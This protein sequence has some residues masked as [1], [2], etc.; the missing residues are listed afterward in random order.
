MGCLN[1]TAADQTPK[2]GIPYVPPGPTTQS[3]QPPVQRISMIDGPHNGLGYNQNPPLLPPS[4]TPE[5]DG[6]IFVARY[7]YQA[8]TAED[9]S[10]EKGEKLRVSCG[11]KHG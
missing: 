4:P 6:S 8:R 9:L 5:D 7:A 10:F 11:S 3:H 2:S 1:S